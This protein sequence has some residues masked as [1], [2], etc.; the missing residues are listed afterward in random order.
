MPGLRQVFQ[1]ARPVVDAESVPETP[2]P[3]SQFDEMMS[4]TYAV[5]GVPGRP[6]P[7]PGPASPGTEPP[8]RPCP[9]CGERIVVGAAKCRFCD[10][11]FDENLSRSQRKGR[12]RSSAGYDDELSTLDGVLC[13]LCPPAGILAGLAY[14]VT[15]K[16][17]AW[18]VLGMACLG[19]I[20]WWIICLIIS[21]SVPHPPSSGLP[22]DYPRAPGFH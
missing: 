8:R 12:R 6:T 10:A 9:M 11:I 16:Q 3:A 15:G 19:T 13:L 2:P 22:P 4:D 18:K 20:A 5:A 1:I 14:L 7:S 21:L 17:K